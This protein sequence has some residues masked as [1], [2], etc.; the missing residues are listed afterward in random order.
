VHICKWREGVG[1]G[2][3]VRH[4]SERRLCSETGSEGAC[5]GACRKEE[6]LLLFFG[7]K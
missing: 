3:C 1:V 6:A 2:E 5:K 4:M 7:G